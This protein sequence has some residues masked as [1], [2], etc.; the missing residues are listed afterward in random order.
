MST[1]PQCFACRI[2]ATRCHTFQKDAAPRTS[3]PWAA[4]IRTGSAVVWPH[5]TFSN[6]CTPRTDRPSIK[7]S[8]DLCTNTNQPQ[9][10]IRHRT[11]W[12][13]GIRTPTSPP[14]STGPPQLRH[15]ALS[16]ANELTPRHRLWTVDVQ[17]LFE[18]SRRAPVPQLAPGY[19]AYRRPR[20][21]DE[22]VP[23]NADA[24]ELH[25]LSRHAAGQGDGAYYVLVIPICD[26]SLSQSLIWS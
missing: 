16:H 11:P 13:A 2:R 22:G 24:P 12:A 7:R 14:L 18:D 23:A 9:L 19:S 10:R 8:T 1:H 6:R 26:I 3:R 25:G 4:G 15:T 5:T 21:E 20:M 17:G